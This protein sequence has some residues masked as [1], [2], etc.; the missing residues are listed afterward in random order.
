MKGNLIQLRGYDFE[1]LYWTLN[2]VDEDA[3]KES[4][5][6]FEIFIEG[7]SDEDEIDFE[8]WWN[9]DSHENQITRVHLTEIYL[10]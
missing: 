6:K 2:S 7:C 4:Y 9:R 5:R 1:E 10:N 8:E 3:I